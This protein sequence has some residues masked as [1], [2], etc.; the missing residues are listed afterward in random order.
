M[1]N[2][3]TRRFSS[4]TSVISPPSTDPPAPPSTDPP[5]RGLDTTSVISP[6]STDPPAPPSTDPPARGLDLSIHCDPQLANQNDTQRL[7]APIEHPV[8]VEQNAPS[9]REHFV[10]PPLLSLNEPSTESVIEPRN[11]SDTPS[12]EAANPI[13][14]T[15]FGIGGISLAVSG[16]PDSIRNDVSNHDVFEIPFL[17]EFPASKPHSNFQYQRPPRSPTT[18]SRFSRSMLP[19]SEQTRSMDHSASSPK[20]GSLAT[21]ISALAKSIH[22]NVVE[23]PLS[24][25]CVGAY[26]QHDKTRTTMVVSF[27]R[28]MAELWRRA[29]VV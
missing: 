25:A 22:P 12:H 10:R 16:R 14:A 15:Q 6:P 28:R 8:M 9:T 18:F 19:G 5:A 17:D 3:E 2:R 7:S 11:R 4:T 29:T 21:W 27:F 13:P 23:H 24:L 26:P 20:V 1:A